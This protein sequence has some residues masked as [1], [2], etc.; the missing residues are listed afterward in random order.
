MKT[1]LNLFVLSVGL[2]L[3]LG[4]TAKP[5]PERAGF[6]QIF[7]LIKTNLVDSDAAE[8]EKEA[9]RG[10]IRRFQGDVQLLRKKQKADKYTGELLAKPK[11]FGDG[12]GYVRVKHVATGLAEAVQLSVE[13]FD[14]LRGLLVDLRFAGGGDYAAAVATANQFI[15]ADGTAITVGKQHLRTQ[16]NTNAI[17]TPVT[18][19][20]NRETTGAAEV[21]AALLRENG[22][23]LL[24]GNQTSGEMKVFSEFEIGEGSRLR[25]AT[26]KVRLG[27]G[28]PISKLEPDIA[29]EVSSAAEKRF[30][31][32][33]IAMTRKNTNRG[34]V[35]EA[36]LVRRLK[37][38][39][40]PGAK[41]DKTTIPDDAIEVIDPV[42]AR[43]LDLFKGLSV[44]APKVEA[45]G[46]LPTPPVDL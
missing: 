10:L 23:G 28:K 24:I 22:V 1:E 4:A 11:V 3:P 18:V 42:L 13:E 41:V 9:V 25:I 8:F 6:D 43:A 45:S 19:L 29:V 16:L 30:F 39:N 31:G 37:L 7:Q 15:D 36:E 46:K 34:K 21:L 27:N 40:N 5:A 20:V 26:D 14:S 38:R 33:D 12:I 2:L 32:D 35:N 17:T 44:Y